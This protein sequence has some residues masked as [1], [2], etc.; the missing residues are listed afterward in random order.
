[1]ANW[2]NQFEITK[3]A[4]VTY[5]LLREWGWRLDSP[6]GDPNPHMIYRLDPRI[7]SA[8]EISPYNQRMDDW[9]VFLRS[10]IA[11]SR[12]RFVFLRSVKRMDQLADLIQAITDRPPQRVE[13]DADQFAN[14]LAAERADCERRYHEYARNERW[15][16]VP[17]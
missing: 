12:C 1:M 11:H 3:S 16:H 10:D 17:G 5:H 4:A 9:C 15:G 6:T 2:E 14:S 8:L 13:F 7:E